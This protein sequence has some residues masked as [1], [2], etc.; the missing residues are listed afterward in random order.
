MRTDLYRRYQA[1]GR[2]LSAH[3]R[4]CESC[5]RADRD[6]SGR[7]ARCPDGARLHASLAR[8]QDTYLTHLKDRPDKEKQE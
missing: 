6:H 5:T 3:D 4:R 8:L 2:A 7:T 1:A